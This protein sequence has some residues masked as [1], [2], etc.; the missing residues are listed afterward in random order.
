MTLRGDIFRWG[1]SGVIMELDEPCHRQGA[2]RLCRA[3][4][5]DSLEFIKQIS[6]VCTF[7][8]VATYWGNI[9]TKFR[10][11]LNNIMMSSCFN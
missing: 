10:Y 5:E 9:I 2:V 1:L 11:E 6:S 8:N 3:N 4:W 7:H